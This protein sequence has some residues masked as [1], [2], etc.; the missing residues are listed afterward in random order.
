[1]Q[2][3]ADLSLCTFFS[4][5]NCVKGM[6]LLLTLKNPL[7][8]YIIMMAICRDKPDW[9]PLTKKF[10]FIKTPIFNAVSALNLLHS[11]D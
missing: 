8:H 5:A 1:M 4:K 10:L 2:E 3:A 6:K 7:L 9:T 11:T